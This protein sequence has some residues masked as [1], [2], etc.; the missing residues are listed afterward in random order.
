MLL[1][2][3]DGLIVIETGACFVERVGAEVDLE[4]A[5]GARVGVL[6]GLDDELMFSMSGSERKIS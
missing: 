5:L 4:E 6:E 3:S 2:K 1:G